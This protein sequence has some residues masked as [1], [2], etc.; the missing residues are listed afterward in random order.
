MARGAVSL[1]VRKVPSKYVVDP[2]LSTQEQAASSLFRSWLLA[3][4][5][6]SDD[7]GPQVA[8][9]WDFSRDTVPCSSMSDRLFIRCAEKDFPIARSAMPHG[10]IGS[11]GEFVPLA[12]AG[13]FD[14]CPAVS[15]RSGEFHGACF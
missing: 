2:A 9:F 14:Y 11:L 7:A 1:V 3:D 15:D 10:G 4:G 6:A 5:G 13:A 8:G 12:R